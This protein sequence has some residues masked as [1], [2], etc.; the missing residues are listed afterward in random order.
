MILPLKQGRPIWQPEK[1]LIVTVE[2]GKPEWTPY[3]QYS[4][5]SSNVSKPQKHLTSPLSTCCREQNETNIKENIAQQLAEWQNE[6]TTTSRVVAFSTQDCG[7]RIAA[8]RNIQP[9]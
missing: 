9:E 3:A 2:T 6:T 1:I 7:M 8:R 4:I 5:Y